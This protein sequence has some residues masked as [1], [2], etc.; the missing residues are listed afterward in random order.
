MRSLPLLSCLLCASLALAAC[1]GLYAIGSN[2]EAARIAGFPAQRIIFL[3]FV[4]CGA[5]SGLGGFLY[6]ARYANITVVAAQGLEIQVIAASVV[7]GVS[8]N[9]GVGTVVGS[10]LGAILI[11]L[12]KQSL[13]RWLAISEFWIEAILGVLILGTVAIDYIVIN[14]LRKAWARSEYHISSESDQVI[15]KEE[16]G[17]V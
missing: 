2:G 14:R 10:T 9:G 1:N 6:L 11:E 7:G 8:I 17:H 5:L 3:A 12:I 13:I 15:A 4:L 16:A